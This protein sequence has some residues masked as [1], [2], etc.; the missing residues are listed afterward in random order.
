MSVKAIRLWPLGPVPGK[1]RAAASGTELG[2]EGATEK[3]FSGL[4]V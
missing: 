3:G 2:D 4:Q 1:T